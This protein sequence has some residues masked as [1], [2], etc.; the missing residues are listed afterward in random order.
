MS[1]W[2]SGYVSELGYTYGYYRELNP[3]YI[4]FSLALRGYAAPKVETALELGFGQGISV[5]FHAA[6]SDVN[7]WGTD[8]N[9]S[10]ASFA[11]ELSR[12][13]GSAM[14]LFDDS[15][16]EFL[17]RSDLPNFDF[18]GL[19]GIW[20]WISD[21]NRSVIVELLR[22]KLNVG[23]VLYI[24]YNTLPGWSGFAPLRHLMT[25]HAE[26][27]G[28][29]GT[30]IVNRIEDAINF[31]EKM[32]SRDPKYA[33][34]FPAATDRIK[35]LKEHSKH[36]LAHEYFNRD[37]HPMH[38]ATMSDWLSEAKLEY[39]G[40]A[41]FL[42]H[43]DTINFTEEQQSLLGEMTDPMFRESVKDFVL[44]QMFRRDYWV[45]GLRRL[46]SL[47]QQHL[48][49]NQKIVLVT[50]PKNIKLKVKGAL[51]EADLHEEIYSPVI[52]SLADHE[53]HS[54]QNVLDQ[55]NSTNPE[56]NASFPQILQAAVIL[57]GNG[58]AEI[59]QENAPAE[60]FRA[61]SAEL[62]EHLRKK[63]RAGGDIGFLL[64]PVTGG[65]IAVNRI[66]Q[67]FL[68]L[69]KEDS[70]FSTEGL[71]QGVW[72]ILQR[73]NQRILKKGKQLDSEDENLAELNK[74]AHLFL[75]EKLEVYRKLNVL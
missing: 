63:A 67:L 25:L 17:A 14:E 30:G 19:H 6:G 54:L 70:D 39:A 23:G 28:S 48:L 41:D 12:A 47:D 49:E 58:H 69:I 51:G 8:F 32:L 21:C 75:D 7:W 33:T 56:L 37:W 13:S 36:Y 15:F 64:S 18:I 61:R 50:P 26:V 55:V 3:K 62:N 27:L 31:A 35:A 66:D 45:K 71:T 74:Q 60:A 22:T 34:A 57:I 59:A 40:P 9:P 42:S 72:Q 11:S 1:E 46:N 52:E 68:Q 5:N 65:G 43:V 73:Q 38:F 16:E 53:A 20:S 4:P 29:Q 2:S 44:N 24:S 10:Q